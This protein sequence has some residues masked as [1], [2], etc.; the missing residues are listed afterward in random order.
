MAAREQ[1]TC[2]VCGHR[3]QSGL[4]LT[5]TDREALAAPLSDEA[6]NRTMQ[7]TLPPLVR[8]P[9]VKEEETVGGGLSGPRFF[10]RRAA[11]LA[12]AAAVLAAA[13][14][15]AGW[16]HLR[17]ADAGPPS[18][19]GVWET[20]TARGASKA[21]RL[22]IILQRGG[23]GALSWTAD[24]AAVPAEQTP[25]RWHLTP[26]GRLMLSL[27]PAAADGSSAGAVAAVLGAHPWLWRVDRS[28]RRLILGTFTFQE[29]Q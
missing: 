4:G 3:F 11:W 2:A 1:G 13:G 27:P 14:G 7:F 8:P 23:G 21:A 26:E 28:H 19:V 24:G 17:A 18:P 22:G 6:R 16:R 9:E 15:A 12:A 5:G 25:L 20:R 10:Q 29:R